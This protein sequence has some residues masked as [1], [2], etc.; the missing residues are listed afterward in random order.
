VADSNPLCVDASV[1]L[2]TGLANLNICLERAL[3]NRLLVDRRSR[4]LL[5]DVA[6]LADLRHATGR[7]LPL[8]GNVI[9]AVNEFTDCLAPEKQLANIITP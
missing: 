5:L 6:P 9:P 2:D 1:Q 4:Q 7:R 3:F 8:I